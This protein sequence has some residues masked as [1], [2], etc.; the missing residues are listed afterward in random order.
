MIIKK[1]C[2]AGIV[3]LGVVISSMALAQDEKIFFHDDFNNLENWK[4]LNFPKIKRHTLYSTIQ[5][6]TNSYLKAESNA[7]AS[8]IILNNEFRVFDYPKIRWR[9][10][11]NNVFAKG[12]AKTR[13]GDDY[14]LR[15]YI[16]FK[17]EPET[18]SFVEKIKYAIAGGLYG[19]DPPHSSLNYIWANREHEETVLVSPYADKSMMI[20][21]KSGA[22]NAD[23][24]IQEEVNIVED[25]HKA[26]GEDPPSTASLAI[27]NDSDNTGESAVSYIDY[28]EIYR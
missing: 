10:K 24:W 25:Y 26:F 5:D 22:E 7:S 20:P 27:M 23:R 19:D 8:G 17:Y 18:A 2:L 4:P 13:D 9:W 21:L 16:V 28:I 6:G 14:P 15:I 12:N 3:M 1:C 11:I